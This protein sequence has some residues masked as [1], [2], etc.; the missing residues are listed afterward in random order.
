MLLLEEK[1]LSQ[2]YSCG[3]DIQ[4]FLDSVLHLKRAVIADREYVQDI[5]AG[6]KIDPS[7]RELVVDFSSAGVSQRYATPDEI[8]ER[9]SAQQISEMK[10][11]ASKGHLDLVN[12]QYAM[13]IVYVYQKWETSIRN[14]MKCSINTSHSD[15]LPLG[16]DF[17]LCND[18]FGDLR[19]I[20]NAYLHR[21]T[22]KDA[23]RIKLLSW[24]QDNEKIE[25]QPH[26][27]DSITLSFIENL[28][29]FPSSFFLMNKEK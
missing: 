7:T 18:F 20:R 21:G 13:F 5:L 19:L 26:Q 4:W 14:K 17:R 3:E 12:W 11:R 23:D 28:K 1:H 24:F 25:L 27:M 2:S 15:I 29:N 22:M 9:M 6:N 8:T 16:T 10:E